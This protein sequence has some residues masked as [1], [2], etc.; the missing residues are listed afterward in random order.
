AW[1]ISEADKGGS[2]R[3]SVTLGFG[4]HSETFYSEPLKLPAGEWKHLAVTY[5]AAGRV[6]FYSNGSLLN[7]VYKPGLGAIVPGP[8]LLHLGDRIGSNYGGFSGFVDEVRICEGALLFQPVSLA[9]QSSRKVWQRMESAAPVELV[10]TNLRRQ[11]VSGASLRLTFAGKEQTFQLPELKAG[12]RHSIKFSVDTALKPESYTLVARLESGAATSEERA[13]FRIVPRPSPQMPVVLWGTGDIP[14][15][16]D[17]GFT[18]FLGIRAGRPGE[19][20]ETRTDNQKTPP[21][22]KP[23]EIQTQME[24]LDNALAEGLNVIT[25]LSPGN[26]AETQPG[27]LQ[28]DRSGKPYAKTALNASQPELPLFFEKVGRSVSRAYGQH[29]AFAAGLVSTEVRDASQP[30]FDPVNVE[31]Y[32]KFANADIPAEVSHRWGVDW[33][34]LAGFPA[35]RMIPEDHPILKYYRWFWT[36]GDG[37][38]GLHSSLNKGLKS[39]V[40]RDF[41]TFFD[42][43]VR[44]PSIS[45]AGGNVDV[46]AH[47]TYTYPDPQRIGLCTDQ[48]LAMSEA[49]GRRQRV[50][51]MTQIIWYRSQTAPLKAGQPHETVAWEDHDP[52]AAYITISPMHLKEAFWTKISRPIEGIMYHGWESLVPNTTPSLYKYTNPNTV[53]VLKQ[54]IH[55]VIRPLGPTL[56]SLPDE[57]AEVVMLESFTSQMFARRGGYGSNIG[58]AAD[59]WMALQ[60]A[61]VRTDILFEETLVK[62]GLSGRKILVMADCDV[63]TEPV[64]KRIQEWQ[65][66]GGKVIADENLC[67]AL[68][69]DHVLTNYKRVK[70]AA[71]D[72][73]HLLQLA[74]D[75]QPRIA[76]LGH[77]P[78]VTADSPEVILRTRRFGDALYVFA[79]NDRREAGTYVGQH[80]LV[81]ENGLPTS[82]TLSLTQDNATVYDLTRQALV[83]PQRD[84]PGNLTWKADLGPCDGRIFMVL[85]KP[86][87]GLKAEVPQ[88]AKCGQTAE[89]RISLTTTQDAPL[90]A[91]V[92]LSVEIRDANGKTAEG[93]GHYA[94]ENGILALPLAIAINDDPGTWEIRVKELASGMESTQWMAVSR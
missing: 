32:R 89:V 74:A 76:A 35:D 10:C 91:V 11:N 68:K 81:L 47:W 38:N 16:K 72:K 46:L 84:T 1:Q 56:M 44:Q 19:I 60:H 67:P 71:E 40:R 80:G 21:P 39:H 28:V 78:K 92:P 62:N 6:C 36:V 77:T 8:R 63:L 85:P 34:K 65:K 88:T 25:T 59:V 54:L 41:W 37:W 2:R 86:L 23:E 4:A 52:D 9:I 49:S 13:E 50:M 73:A 22:D 94:A 29:P 17:I 64:V 58:W 12:A 83:I 18:H 5:D 7:A 26:F 57:R 90:K 79:I 69:A 87:L 20:W 27:M 51:K 75:L 31:N 82:A 15:M 70:K 66:K 53:H 55:D 61:H 3:L 14:R 93:S 24:R 45:G 48:L 42:P 33:T 43:A 30:S